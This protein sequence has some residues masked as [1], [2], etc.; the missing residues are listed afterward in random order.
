MGLFSSIGKGISSVFKGAKNLV[1]KA[2]PLIGAVSSFIPGWGTI[3]NIASSL[4]GSTSGTGGAGSGLLGLL[5][6]YL[7]ELASGGLQAYSSA[8]QQQTAIEEAQKARDFNAGQAAISRDFSSAEALRQM[9]FQ[10][11]MANTSHQRQMAD[12]KAAGLNP[13][14]AATG[15][16]PSPGGAMGSAATASGPAAQAIDTLGP[17]LSTAMGVA[18]L[19]QQLRN[20]KQ[21][22]KTEAER[23]SL[24]Q[25]QA[26]NTMVNSQ[27]GLIEQRIRMQDERTA[28]AKADIAEAA[29][30]G[31][32]NQESVD[33]MAGEAGPFAKLLQSIFGV[34]HSARGLMK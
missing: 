9:Q 17:A 27:S 31:A 16:A 5:Q 21:I 12:L 2:A 22:E 30:A 25:A 3:G 24:T 11:R 20:Q 8:K 1:G 6:Q 29:V 4:I 32:K 13:I 10:E 33:K 28:R 18:Q 7:P 34:G 14:L 19:K 23:T 15:G 26:Y